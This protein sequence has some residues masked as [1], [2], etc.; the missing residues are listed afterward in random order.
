MTVKLYLIEPEDV[1]AVGNISENIDEATINKAIKISQDQDIKP[2]IG[3]AL[4]ID[5]LNTTLS[6]DLGKLYNGCS[7]T[8]DSILYNHAGIKEACAYYASARLMRAN[9]INITQYGVVNKTADESQ[10][11]SEKDLIAQINT[12]TEIANN[13]IKET[14]FYLESF[15]LVFTTYLNTNVRAQAGMTL[16]SIGD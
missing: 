2:A 1:I 9:K 5:L 16:T 8:V 7:F 12:I 3:T 10:Q 6:A 4:F 14:I 13:Y 11:V 15:P